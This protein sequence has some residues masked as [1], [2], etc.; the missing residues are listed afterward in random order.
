MVC[1]LAPLFRGLPVVFLFITLSSVACL[2]ALRT[3]GGGTFSAEPEELDRLS[4]GARRLIEQ[5]YQGMENLQDFHVHLVGRGDENNGIYLNP[6]WQSCFHPAEY[7]RY[8][9]IMSAGG[10]RD[11]EKAD[12][13]YASRLV[14][15]ARNIKNP[16]R[17]YLLAFDKFYNYAGDV[18]L[19]ET[20]FYIPDGYVG[21]TAELYDDVFAPAFS[22]HPYDPRA[23]DRL[24][25]FRVRLNR[26]NKKLVAR[27][28]KP[29][30][31][32]V[33]WLPSVQGIDPSS[34]KADAFYK[35]MRTEGL[36]LLS[37]AGEEKAIPSKEVYARYNNPLLLR[38]A[39][40]LGVKVIIAHCGGL[41]TS[42][43][44]RGATPVEKNNFALFIEMMAMDRYRGLLFG[45]I[46]AM[47]QYNRFDPVKYEAGKSGYPLAALLKEYKR[48]FQ[49]R[50]VNGSDYPLPALDFLIRTGPI[51]KAGLIQDEEREFLSEIYDYNP[52][53]FDFVL[54]RTLRHQK[55]GRLPAEI[56]QYNSALLYTQKERK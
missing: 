12:N 54:K 5:A 2:P 17:Y 34:A 48:L 25:A 23:P 9:G 4:P 18:N 36:V 15:L 13:E 43:D 47:M 1:L 42:M 26:F 35:T 44:F 55:Y 33:K 40:D 41:G 53:L 8:L 29:L 16:G 10:V 37:H 20:Q 51:Y 39:L 27:G 11:P 7:F 24:R 49:G 30:P 14:R 52:L 19:A 3:F 32:I 50:L 56:F 6:R 45:E 21:D 38:R 28:E 31:G 46:S 22:V